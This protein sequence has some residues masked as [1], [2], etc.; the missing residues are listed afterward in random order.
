M[1]S[2]SI[3]IETASPKWRRA[4][5]RQ[6]VKIESAAA[7]AVLRAKKPAALKKREL[8]IGITLADNKTI[9]KLNRVW[10][11]K[12]TPTN[13]L[14]FPQIDCKHLRAGDLT[15]FPRQKPLPLGDVILAYETIQKEAKNQGKK[16]EDHVIHLIIHGVLHLFGYDHMSK[17]DAK[18]M[19][20]LECDIL[21]VLG[22][23]DP[24]AD[25]V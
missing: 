2:V 6:Q 16:L 14:S 11:G 5:V 22:Y 9:K 4:F 13:V 15:P 19:E 20:K 21:A 12:D 18:T 17:K 7:I 3:T 23:P 8:A 10:R 24:Y 25:P 1:T